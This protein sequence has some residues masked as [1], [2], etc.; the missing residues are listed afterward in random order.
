MNLSTLYDSIVGKAALKLHEAKTAAK[1]RLDNTK[2]LVTTDVNAMHAEGQMA[3]DSLHMVADHEHDKLATF[4]AMAVA[5]AEAAENTVKHM[6]EYYGIAILAT[7]VFSILAT[8]VAEHL[9]K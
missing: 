8:I 4:G 1:M 6:I 3:L 9:L 7:A 2:S 5:R